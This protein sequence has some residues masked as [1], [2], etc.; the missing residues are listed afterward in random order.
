LASVRRPYIETCI[1]AF[2]PDRAMFEINLPDRQDQ[3]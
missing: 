1:A 3:P 2:D